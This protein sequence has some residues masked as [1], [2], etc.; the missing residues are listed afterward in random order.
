MRLSKILTVLVLSLLTASGL[1]A[2]NRTVSGKVLDA[3]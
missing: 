3:Q 1:W 2:Q